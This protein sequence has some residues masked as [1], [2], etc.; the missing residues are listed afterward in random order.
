MSREAGVAVGLMR[1]R[2]R[3]KERNWAKERSVS[4]SERVGEDWVWV[5]VWER[6]SNFE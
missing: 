6:F 2:H 5:W 1:E 4:M 3:F